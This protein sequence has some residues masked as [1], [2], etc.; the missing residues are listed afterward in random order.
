MGTPTR[1]LLHGALLLV[2]TSAA[3]H[4]EEPQKTP[5]EEAASETFFETRVRPV[6]AE[7][8]A[9]CHGEKRQKAGLRFDRPDDLTKDDGAGPI[10]LAGNP[11]NSRLVH[12]LR[13]KGEIRMP[14]K[15]RLPD[16]D[17]E[18]V[19]AWVQAG[20]RWPQRTETPGVQEPEARRITRETH[21]AYRPVEVPDELRENPNAID[22]LVDSQ[23]RVAGLKQNESADRRRLIRRL[24][25]DLRGLPPTPAEVDEF[26]ADDEPDAWEKIVDRYLASPRRGERWGRHWLDLAR[27]ADNKGY[28]FQEERRYPYSH[29]Y[30]EY[31]IESFWYDRPYDEFV[32]EQLAADLLDSDDPRRL[33]ALGFLTLGR[34]FLNN[35][36][37]IID[38]RIDVTTRGLLGLTVACAR[39][40]DHKY[41]PIPTADYYSLY[42]I[43]WSSV[44][45]KE[46][47]I[48]GPSPNLSLATE[49][50]EKRRELEEQLAARKK[51]LEGEPARFRR[52]QLRKIQ[53]K[54]DRLDATHDGAPQRAMALVDRDRPA[55]QPILV[56][57]NRGRRGKVVARR[58]LEVL[59]GE[60][61]PSF[62]EGS[63]R[64]EL[65]RSIAS[66]D[67]PL[68]ARVIVNRVFAHLFGAP[69]VS[70]QSDFGVRSDPPAH[71]ELLDWLASEL[72]ADGWSLRSLKRRICL[73]R[74]YRASSAP[75]E[76]ARRIDPENR[77]LWRQNPRRI[78]FEVLRD[79][80]LFVAGRLDTRFGGRSKD[81][82]E[83]PFLR[84]R[85]IYGFIDRQNVP[86]TLRNFDV[87]SPDSS[88]AGRHQTT[89]PQ[90]ALWLLNG[91]FLA[92]Q[93]RA[94]I[95]RADSSAA[96]GRKE[97]IEQIYR[98]LFARSPDAAEL[99]LAADFLRDDAAWPRYAEALL[100]LNEL[101]FID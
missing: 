7:H 23:L 65:A 80:L 16:R 59:S 76:D 3:I 83:K 8:C 41:D 68:T 73:S 52:E 1:Q 14:P 40:H 44:E 45:P 61:R 34:R 85:A 79:S 13:H 48:V 37:D 54:I 15:K 96:T 89:V 64:L 2:L 38:D 17:I 88:S 91:P 62:K 78:E 43:F 47:P 84:R 66:P 87:A 60:K 12:V 39:C 26:L 90:Q 63:G 27:Y 28:V 20:A 4:A 100:M 31:V 99:A 72:V 24:S 51:E 93:A 30:R 36:Q 46:L 50:E 82:F 9:R 33:R 75:R 53:K 81:L 42:G 35:Q 56:R 55:D 11:A 32:T 101:T 69:L 92:E 74:A 70:T 5:P 49:Y 98:R 21:W 57:G 71:P 22:S 77:L 29:T 19:A 94:L 95:E 86:G 25:F 97:R 58:F 10:V 18:A 67:N 6:F